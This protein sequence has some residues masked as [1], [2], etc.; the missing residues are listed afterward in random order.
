M[1]NQLKLFII[2]LLLFTPARALAQQYG[3]FTDSRDGHVYRTIKIGQQTW[4]ANNMTIKLDDSFPSND[5][6]ELLQKYGYLYFWESA[7]K[8]CPAGW[9]LPTQKEFAE[10]LNNVCGPRNDMDKWPG[11][12]LTNLEKA[13]FSALPAGRYISDSHCP[14]Y[15]PTPVGSGYNC[16]F[17]SRAYLWTATPR[18]RSYAY[19]L[20]MDSGEAYIIFNG[21]KNAFSVRCLKN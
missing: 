12:C 5:N 6:H 14:D 15:S 7:Q 17:G 3:S 19:S 8:A 13:G 1:G 18:R 2:S 16:G 4:M 10:L 21:Q 20:F 9:H 11:N